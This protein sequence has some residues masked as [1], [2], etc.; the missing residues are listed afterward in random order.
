MTNETRT[1]KITGDKGTLDRFEG[2]LNL[3]H[4]AVAFGHSGKIGMPLDGDG[5]ESFTIEQPMDR[6][7][8]DKV[9]GVGYDVELAFDESFS[10]IFTDKN[11]KPKWS[12]LRATGT[13]RLLW[14]ARV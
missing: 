13:R 10:G 6:R 5:P 4:W 8:A 3:L 1:Y 14:S 11:R 12:Y 7:A 2:L 9:F